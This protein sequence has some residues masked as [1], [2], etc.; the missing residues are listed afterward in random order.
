MLVVVSIGG[1]ASP[2][3]AHG[4]GSGG[5]PT[6]YVI[7]IEAISPTT[8]GIRV[9]AIDLGERLEL[10]NDTRS[11]VVVLGYDDEPYLRV[12][13]EGVFENRRSPAT[14]LNENADLTD[15][16]VPD[17]ADPAAPPEWQRVSGSTTARWHD[18]R[19]HWMGDEDPPDVRRDRRSRHV[20]QDW[21]VELRHDGTDIEVRGDIV[22]VPGPSPWPW[23]LF[24]AALGAVLLAASRTRGWRWPVSAGLVVA[25]TAAVGHVLGEWGATTGSAASKLGQGI[26]PLGGVALGGVALAL[27]VMRRDPSDATPA[28]L[29]AGIVLALGSGLA[30]VSAL[31]HSQLLSTQSAAAVR[32]EVVAALGL[33]VGLAAVGASRLRPALTDRPSPGTTRVPG[34]TT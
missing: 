34:P 14:Y 4:G 12:G 31:W 27:L 5:G 24:A 8:P 15:V 23:L 25:M 22:W 7:R 20:V 9:R 16:R 18:H 13:P 11:D 1:A 17:S 2:A 19:A 33:G 32:L 10:R 29:I 3:E 26:Y 30:D 6:N 21:T 28:L